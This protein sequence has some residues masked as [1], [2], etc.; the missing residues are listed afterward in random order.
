MNQ[1]KFVLSDPYLAELNKRVRRTEAFV[2]V[3]P[4]IV[5]L[6]VY[7]NVMCAFHNAVHVV[8]VWVHCNVVV[9]HPMPGLPLPAGLAFS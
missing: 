8:C 9:V 2:F 6:H 7:N 5:P 3:H 1:N 4:H